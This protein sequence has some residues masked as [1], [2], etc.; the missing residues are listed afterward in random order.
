MDP[1]FIPF[2]Q[3]CGFGKYFLR[4][5]GLDLPLPVIM[6]YL[7]STCI[8]PIVFQRIYSEEYT[9]VSVSFRSHS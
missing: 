4:V 6:P 7:A 5:I 3:I 1:H 2:F 8:R 9:A